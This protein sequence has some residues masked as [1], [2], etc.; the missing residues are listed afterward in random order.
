MSVIPDTPPALPPSSGYRVGLILFGSFSILIGV[1]ALLMIPT[2]FLALLAPHQPGQP[3][4]TPQMMI[5]GV[6][7]Y[8]VLAVIDIWLGIG[9][10]LCR[11]WAHALILLWSFFWLVCGV[12]SGII[13]I[14][15]MGD[16]EAGTA[17]SIPN[18]T[19]QMLAMMRMVM[20]CTMGVIYVL[21]P[22]AFVWFYSSK[23]A[24]KTCELQD[25]RER[26]TDRCP[27]PLLGLV[28]IKAAGAVCLPLAFLYA[29][30]FPFFGLYL[31]GIAAVALL[32]LVSTTF[33]FCAWG[34][35][36]RHPQ[37]LWISLGTAL[38]LALSYMGT[39]WN[40]GLIEMYRQMKMPEQTMKMVERMPMLQNPH[41]ALLGLLYLVPYA[42]FILYCRRYFRPVDGR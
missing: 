16:I 25:S 24:R 11:R 29:P 28:M 31:H 21:V 38:F 26:W 27:L 36:R 10:I 39:L 32:L 9:S 34:L 4:F 23:G 2:M 41:V 35:Y 20:L 12:L 19:P 18:A 8:L 13:M 40:T 3:A 1:G 22:G 7:M 5:P 33:G 37:F 17:Q 15:F 42:G 30:I 14:F 6:V